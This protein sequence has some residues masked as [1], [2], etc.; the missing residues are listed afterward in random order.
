MDGQEDYGGNQMIDDMASEAAAGRGNGKR[1]QAQFNSTVRIVDGASLAGDSP[2][3]GADIAPIET[4]SLAAN[5]AFAYNS[6]LKS[7]ATKKMAYSQY[8][9]VLKLDL[10]CVKGPITLATRMLGRIRQCALI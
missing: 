5:V 6:M 4:S 1:S 10:N 9:R 8:W 7:D 2:V 3:F